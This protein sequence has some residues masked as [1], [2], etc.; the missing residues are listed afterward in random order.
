MKLARMRDYSRI[1][2]YIDSM[3]QVWHGPFCQYDNV[4][5]KLVTDQ[6]VGH[7]YLPPEAVEIT[8]YQAA[9]YIKDLQ[10]GYKD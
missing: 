2:Y 5:Y 7:S 1:K 3:G 4:H 10:G 6:A 9:Q 8:P